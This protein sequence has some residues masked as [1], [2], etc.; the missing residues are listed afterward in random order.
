MNSQNLDLENLDT[1]LPTLSDSDFLQLSNAQQ[2][3]YLQ[4]KY[5]NADIDW[6]YKHNVVICERSKSVVEPLISQEFFIDYYKEFA[7]TPINSTQNLAKTNKKSKNQNENDNSPNLETQSSNQNSKTT[8]QKLALEGISEVEFL[9][10]EYQERAAKY[11]GEIK[12]WCISRD[13][14]WGHKMPVWYNLDY[15][16]VRNFYTFEEFA[17][18]EIVLEIDQ[19]I[20]NK[21]NLAKNKNTEKST[22]E[23][24]S[25]KLEKIQ[26]KNKLQI[27]V[28]DCFQ[29]SPTK[30]E[31]AGNWS[32]E[33]K[34]L[35]TWFSSTLWPLSTL[36]FVDFAKKE[37]QKKEI[38]SE[39]ETLQKLL[40]KLNSQ[41]SQI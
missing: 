21:L 19:S 28:Q 7:H 3:T 39:I 37:Q 35:D 27:R 4:K 20:E 32:Q 24:N 22:L 10:L 6:N 34:I 40:T 36:D 31:K 17:K 15:N 13:L 5:P 29:I 23:Q 16:L 26:L 8:L 11:F 14:I 33:I 2:L 1:A 18:N 38:D 9:P 25:K 41:K 12:N 30:P